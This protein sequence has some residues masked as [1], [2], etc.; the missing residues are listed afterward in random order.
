MRYQQLFESNTTL[1]HGDNV[2]TTALN[3]Q[4][5]MHG[6]SNNQ[7]GVG[8]YF[9]PDINAAK[10]YGTK[11]SSIDI[12][13]LKIKK[14]RD[15]V[16]D[17]ISRAAGTKLI[18]HLSKTS[19]DFWY[20]LTDYGIEL[21]EPTDMMDYH[22]TEL[23]DMMKMNE[24]RNWQLELALASDVNAFVAGWNKFIKID[25]IYETDTKFYAIINTDITATPVNF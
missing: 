9:T 6:E 23:F 25:G 20:L 17:V 3:S 1:Y 4:W 11:I 8:I 15:L 22:M 24:I 10:T 19:E 7:E 5:M 21:A 16:V 18:R 13:G 14:S 2:G 12:S